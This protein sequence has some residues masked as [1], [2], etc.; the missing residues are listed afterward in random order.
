LPRFSFS[1][2]QE[3]TAQKARGT[4]GSV[5]RCSNMDVPEKLQQSDL[6]TLRSGGQEAI[7]L[8]LDTS[9][10]LHEMGLTEGLRNWVVLAAPALPEAER[11]EV[12]VL[13]MYGFLYTH[14]RGPEGVVLK[15]VH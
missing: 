12:M 4:G 9:Q 2:F 10:R 11:A 3:Q 8:F 5:L 13:L 14:Y 6:E 7:S 1:E 15:S